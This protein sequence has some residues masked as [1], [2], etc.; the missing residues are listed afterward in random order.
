[1]A[2]PGASRGGMRSHIGSVGARSPQGPLVLAALGRTPP[3]PGRV[4][5]ERRGYTIR[6]MKTDT[7]PPCANCQRLQ[8]RLDALQT[9][10]DASHA[11]AASLREQLAAARK[12]SSN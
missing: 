11:E 2:S 9:Q 3:F 1:M 6:G 8:A 10:L 4:P 7:R 12:D 5:G